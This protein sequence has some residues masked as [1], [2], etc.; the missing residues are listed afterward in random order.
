MSPRA[1]IE[2]AVKGEPRPWPERPRLPGP[3][4]PDALPLEVLPRVLRDFARTISEATQAPQDSAIGVA[5]G[6]VS[7]ALVG[8]ALVEICPRREWRKPAHEYVLIEQPSG[9]G[10]SPLIAFVRQAIAKWEAKRAEEEA[11]DR[12]WAEESVQV[13]VER[14]KVARKEAVRAP[15]EEADAHLRETLKELELAE[16]K[17]RGPY[18]L[19]ISDAT[20]EEVVRVLESNGGRGASV[21]PEGTM[22]EVA[23]GRYGNGDAR[24][25]ALAHGWDGE[26][27]RVNR[28]SRARVDLPSAN[29]AL[30]L[31]L[32]PGILKGM[33]NADTMQQRG[34]LARFLS[35]S[36]P[37]RW[38]KMRTGPD[39]PSLD[40][41]A[42]ERYERM[43]IQILDTYFRD[44]QNAWR[45]LEDG[46]YRRLKPS[47]KAPPFRAQV[48]LY[49]DALAA[50]EQAERTKRT[51]FEPH[52][53]ADPSR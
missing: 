53:A 45:L 8:K 1:V 12:R 18:Q 40:R 30:L 26:P 7:V 46:S 32:Q 47:G 37:I 35:I 41:M 48:S 17:P 51:I 2:A 19:L 14:V 52:Q 13:A 43:L 20:E 4:E 49:E 16:A 44:N 25:A 24:L 23:A 9:T 27:M 33:L 28:V 42:I 39:V 22:L 21:D 15:S 38:N 50:T 6:G 29:L 11:L 36:P 34:I 3:P 10:K 5:L 31:A